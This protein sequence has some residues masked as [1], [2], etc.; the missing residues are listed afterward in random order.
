MSK[1]PQITIDAR[2]IGPQTSGIGRY[3][4]NLI[5]ELLDLDVGLRLHLICDPAAPQAGFGESP[6]V[7]RLSFQTFGAEANSLRTRHVLGRSLKAESDIFHSPFN[8]LPAGLKC[9][10]V[11]TL[12]DIMWLLDVNY[13]TNIWWRK[14]V[15]GTFY[16]TFIPRSVREAD[17]IMTVSHASRQ[18]IEDYFPE[19]KG[20]VHVTYNAVDPYFKPLDPSFAMPLLKTHFDPH[21]PFVLVVGQGTPYKN[22]KGALAGFVQAFEDVPEMK[23]VIVRRLSRTDDEL[24]ELKA[25]PAMQGRI[26]Q[27]EHVSIE[28]LR[29][30]YSM[31]HI[32]LFPSIYEG[33]GLPALEAM[34]CG[35]PVV[36][37]NFGAMAEVAGG[38]AQLVDP[39]DTASIAKGL[40]QLWDDP[41]LHQSFAKRAQARAAEFSW[42]RCAEQALSVYNLMLGRA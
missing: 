2:Y 8:I 7:E 3:T 11:F 39:R 33:F 34:A 36:T 23:F 4:E 17:Q 22:H 37:S 41:E 24:S 5:R 21:D 19:V 28:V 20:R 18:E 27:L 32:F 6:H 30:L 40:R 13:C 1:D 15:T 31:A 16:K 35:T 29:A 12:H 26:I 25:H 14:M 38:A 10:K 42:A 9:K